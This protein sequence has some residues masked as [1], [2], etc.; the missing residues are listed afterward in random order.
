VSNK[1]ETPIDLEKLNKSHDMHALRE[2]HLT[3]MRNGRIEKTYL[4]KLVSEYKLKKSIDPEFP[5]PSELAEVVLIIIDKMLGS[6][7]WRGYSDDWKEEF[8]GR[9]IEHVLKYAHN[10]DPHKSK[11]GKND[12]Y[13]YF[14]MIIGNAFIQSWRKCKTYSDNNVLMNDEIIYN[15]NNW[16]ADQD[17]TTDVDS[18]TPN[19][20]AIDWGYFE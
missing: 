12:P 20:D 4:S 18:I 8:R 14:A 16:A 5:M 7:S 9:A 15:K 3:E 11:S 17:S 13:N 19:I 10:F 1:E 6:A 2:K